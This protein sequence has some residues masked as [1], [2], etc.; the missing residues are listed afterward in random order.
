MRKLL[1]RGN[2]NNKEMDWSRE[3]YRTIFEMVKDAIFITTVDGRIVDVNPSCL[4]LFG[5]R[6]KEEALSLDLASDIYVNT[7]DRTRLLELVERDGFVKDYEIETKRRD[8]T[9]ILI[10]LSDQVIR[11]KKGKTICYVGM[12]RDITQRREYERRLEEYAE[13]LEREVQERTRALRE[14]EEKYRSLFEGSKDALYITTEE[15]KF[16]DLNQATAQL[17]GYADKEELM[18]IESTAQLYVNP[19]DRKKMKEIMS[20]QGYV[21][22]MEQELRRKD[23]TKIHA[24]I[25]G[26]IRKDEGGNVIGYEGMIKDVTEHKRTEERLRESEERLRTLVT[27]APLGLSIIGGD[28]TYEYVNPKFVEMFGYTLDDVPAGRTWF[29]KAY[30]DQEYRRMVITSWKED[31]RGDKAGETRPR[32]FAVTCKDGSKKEVFFRSVTLTDGRQ[33]V[34]YEDITDRKRADEQL[35]DSEERYRSLVEDINDGYFIVQDGKFVYVNQAFANLSGYTKEAILG[36]EFSELLPQEYWEGL[37]GSDG[38]EA[39]NRE[40]GGQHEFEISREGGE[41]LVLEIR[42]RMIEF[43]GRPAIAGICKDITERKKAE[44]ALKEKVEELERWY[45][46]TVDREIKMTELK[47]RIQELESELKEMRENPDAE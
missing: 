2:G 20:E 34:T 19:E 36:K 31:L 8:G 44:V 5:Y 42:S 1:A 40:H 4:E 22:D 17:F 37:S 13:K 47:N 45:H 9:K 12:I 28:G 29:E 3:S 25:T 30:P 6:D 14:S 41:N 23:G 15:G 38:S 21:K 46:L 43:H 11:D 27:S 7:E 33:L 35:R 18:K 16:T 10:S 32:V 24:M 39:G 26:T